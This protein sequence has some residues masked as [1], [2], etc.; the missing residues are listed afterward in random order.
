VQLLLTNKADV[1]LRNRDGQTPLDLAKTKVAQAGMPAV[2]MMPPPPGGVPGRPPGYQ[3]RADQEPQPASAPSLADLL[4]QHGA[5]ENLPRLDV[6]QVSRASANVSTVVFQ[7]GTN[8]W[9]Q[10]SLL[11]AI[12]GQYGLIS[13]Q[14]SGDFQVRSEGIAAYWSRHALRFPDLKN[15]VIHR[16]AADGRSWASIPVN[17]A[18]ILGSGDCSRD[19]ILRWGDVVEIPE[20]DHPVAEQW[21]GL[22]DPDR[23]ALIKCVSRTITVS[24][25]ATN[26]P[27][28]LAPKYVVHPENFGP[29]SDPEVMALPYGQARLTTASFML[30]SVLDQSKLIR[31]SS[32]LTRVKVTRRDAATGQTRDWV[33]DCSGSNAPDFWLRDGDVIEVPEK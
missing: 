29:M 28:N 9:N 31:F 3:Q 33:L 6:I 4:R 5:L 10:F 32:D 20:A 25:N 19:V 8:D 7:K 24:I 11:E 27:L 23:A 16:P 26:T 14:R 17:V 12:A 1:N 18:D 2:P 30:R 22:T 21:K 13:N 15:V